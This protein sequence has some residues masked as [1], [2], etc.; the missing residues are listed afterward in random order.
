MK[1]LI[2]RKNELKKLKQANLLEA[3]TIIKGA[4]GTGKT[5]LVQT[6]QK[7]FDKNLLWI[8]ADRMRSIEEIIRSE[9]EQHTS[10][11]SI[12]KNFETLILE[13]L[14]ITSDVDGIVWDNFELIPDLYRSV[15]FDIT[16][17]SDFNGVHYFLTKEKLTKKHDVSDFLK[18]ELLNFSK[19]EVLEFFQE[20]DAEALSSSS[21]EKIYSSTLGN[22]YLIYL[23]ILAD[24]DISNYWLKEYENLNEQQ[25]K[26]IRL[27]CLLGRPVSIDRI[28]E[29]IVADDLKTMIDSMIVREINEG[30]EIEVALDV[31][32]FMTHL[33][34]DVWSNSRHDIIKFLNTKLEDPLELLYHL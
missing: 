6:F 4:K 1:K 15:I 32:A 8:S 22:P 2:G 20:I 28:N 5:T 25:K 30:R 23:Y 11:K 17:K 3:N 33:D 29:L 24:G 10:H 27:L 31:D 21:L 13:F 16:S 7:Q 19:D 14:K 9:Y 34:E 12:F 18:I 26:T